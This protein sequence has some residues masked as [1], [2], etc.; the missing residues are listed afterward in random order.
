MKIK[1]TQLMELVSKRHT[2]TH[3]KLVLTKKILIEVQKVK[4]DYG[5][6][7]EK[8][9]NVY[10]KN[11]IE[12]LKT[13]PNRDTV[14]FYPDMNNQVFEYM[15]NDDGLICVV[16]FFHGNSVVEFKMLFDFTDNTLSH[17]MTEMGKKEIS[18]EM[19]IG[20]N[21]YSGYFKQSIEEFMFSQI[22][23]FI[24]KPMIFIEKSETRVKLIDIKPS[25]KYGDIFKNNNIINKTN[26]T[27]TFVDSLWNV[28]IISLGEFIVRGHFRLQRCGV[29][30]SEI[31]L[32]Y[33]DTFTKDHYI[34]KSTR[35]MVFN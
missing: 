13:L 22:N 20:L 15:K 4:I 12:V 24:I 26:N 1:N 10:V 27:F 14:L 33:I 34:R 18:L 30:Y 29:G 6:W 35:E 3:K 16:N 25:E 11:M 28:G 8:D 7:I 5:T 9:W 31:K 21:K 32:I 2:N 19:S 23:E 17:L